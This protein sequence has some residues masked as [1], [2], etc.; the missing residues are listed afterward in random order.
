MLNTKI[1]LIIPIADIIFKNPV[2]F[3][4]A[5]DLTHKIIAIISIRDVNKFIKVRFESGCFSDGMRLI[6]NE[7]IYILAIK[8]V[9]FFMF[10]PH[11]SK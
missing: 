10:F 1:P 9:C 5:T 6:L 11:F 2:F 3:E 8:I 7:T 4:V